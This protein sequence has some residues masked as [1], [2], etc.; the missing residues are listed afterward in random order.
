MQ[1]MYSYFRNTGRLF[2]GCALFVARCNTIRTS[3]ETKKERLSYRKTYIEFVW[4]ISLFWLH[5]LLSISFY[6][7]LR[8]LPPSSQVMPL[9]SDAYKDTY[10]YASYSVRWYHKWTV[11]NMKIY[12][13]VLYASF[14]SNAFFQLTLSVA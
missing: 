12:N 13:S 9:R 14:T 7:F 10:C 5:A 4:G 11:E 1:I 8:L 2:L 6:C 3:W